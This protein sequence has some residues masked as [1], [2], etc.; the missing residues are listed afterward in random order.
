[1]MPIYSHSRL[2]S[3]ET[4][5]LKYRYSYVDR[6][7]LDPRPVG[8]EAFMGSR[9]HDTLEKLYQ[10]LN[11]SKENTIDEILGFYNDDWESN[12]HD[13]VK[14]VK[15]GYTPQNYRDT[16]EKCIRD[17][18]S[19]HHPF[20]MP[21][22]ISLEKRVV[23]DIDGHK[24]QG[25]IDRLTRATGGV[26][27]IHDY[28]T[29]R[30]MPEQ[31]HADSDRQLA[32]YQM[33]VEA[34]WDDV[35]NVDLVWHYLVHDRRLRSKRT[36]AEL[37]ELKSLT[38]ALIKDIEKA[39][40][41]YDFPLKECALCPWCEFQSICP[42]WAHV[43]KTGQMSLN[44]Y[45]DEPGVKL[46]NEYS[47]LTTEKKAIEKELDLVKGAL[48]E[49]ATKEGVEVI[50][51]DENKIRIRL[52]KKLKFPSKKDPMRGDLERLIQTEGKWMDVSDLSP[53]ALKAAVEGGTWSEE[54]IQRIK[55]FQGVEE[56]Y[57]V[58]ISKK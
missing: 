52:D 37:D 14:I 13:N 7:K 9:V 8:I 46:A 1:M 48:I 22:T 17:Y 43:V 11:V 56:S 23:I 3:Y 38:I 51:G 25:F 10:D 4:C 18:Y 58:T 42:N 36:P 12:W 49:F 28:K 29:S 21:R 53:W 47:R 50:A 55:A 15:K 31:R 24:I 30:N 20:D 45:M 19:R 34:M 33:G 54:L 16:G 2:S 26:Y 40:D 39:T 27:E 57:R 32:L 5:P 44:R 35:R 6:I 41:E